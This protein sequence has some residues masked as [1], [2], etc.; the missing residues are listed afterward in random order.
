MSRTMRRSPSRWMFLPA[1]LCTLTVSCQAVCPLLEPLRAADG[2][3]VRC[4]A[5]GECPRASTDLVCADTED[6]LRGCIDC[7]ESR[8]VSFSAGV[9]P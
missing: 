1:L 3:V 5:A 9:C 2:G 8:C 6:R 7:V 4:A